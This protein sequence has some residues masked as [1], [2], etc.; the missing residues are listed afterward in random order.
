MSHVDKEMRDLEI[1]YLF[2]FAPPSFF[3]PQLHV[4]F[5][6]IVTCYITTYNL[7]L[8]VIKNTGGQNRID[9]KRELKKLLGFIAKK[10]SK[11]QK[12][13]LPTKLVVGQLG[14][15]NWTEDWKADMLPTGCQNIKRRINI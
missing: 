8:G 1:Y 11:N 4:L 3:D 12:K 6:Y 2:C 10:G 5:S 14:G 13:P 15:S 9:P 7:Q